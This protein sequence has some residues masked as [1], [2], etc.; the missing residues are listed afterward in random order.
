MERRCWAFLRTMLR[1]YQRDG[2]P[3]VRIT[4][5]YNPHLLQYLMRPELPASVVLFKTRGE[6][7][8]YA[9]LQGERGRPVRVVVEIRRDK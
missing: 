4:P 3:W 2:Y 5:S 7:Q 9:W 8:A 1:D 6:A